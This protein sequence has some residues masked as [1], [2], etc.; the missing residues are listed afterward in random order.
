MGESVYNF[1]GK[2]EHEECIHQNLLAGQHS[3]GVI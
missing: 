3:D 2:V 1:T